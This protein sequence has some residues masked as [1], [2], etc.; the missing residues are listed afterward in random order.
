MS[1]PRVSQEEVDRVV[2]ALLEN[3]ASPP[4]QKK[5]RKNSQPPGADDF[6]ARLREVR[7]GRKLKQSAMARLLGFTE[8]YYQRIESGRRPAPLS[9]RAAV[10]A[11]ALGEGLGQVF[12]PEREGVR[13]APEGG[14]PTPD[15]VTQAEAE[16]C[17]HPSALAARSGRVQQRCAELHDKCREQSAR[18]AELLR[19][20]EAADS[21]ARHLCAARR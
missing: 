17:A 15:A 20:S 7:R 19:R 14:L 2:R 12:A 4:P 18:L 16:V 10:Y 5:G 8:S 9:F 13:A 3:V 11:W 6:A 1:L 21:R